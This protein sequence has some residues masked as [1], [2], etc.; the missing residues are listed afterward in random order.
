MDEEKKEL[1][2]QE[3]NEIDKAKDTDD[4]PKKK[5]AEDVEKEMEQMIQDL[6]EQ[7]GIDKN[8]IKVVSIKAPKRNFKVILFESLYYI[9]ITAL[10]F[11]GLSGYIAWCDGKWYDLLFFSLMFSAI[12]LVLRNVFYIIFKK[13]IVQTFGFIM[14]LPP[15]I[16]MFVCVFI[17]F[18]I[19]PVYIGRYIIVCVILL[20][21]REFIKK[22]SID[23]YFRHL[24]KNKK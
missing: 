4:K 14:V 8:Q 21:V 7:M 9:I 16:S 23:F 15:L 11:V 19:S 22:Y 18:I 17:P 12:E 24:R 3:N 5:T 6:S 1:K 13:T 20:I 10:M 2:D